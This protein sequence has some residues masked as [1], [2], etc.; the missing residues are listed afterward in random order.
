MDPFNGIAE[1][2][3]ADCIKRLKLLEEVQYI[4]ENSETTN[5]ALRLLFKHSNFYTEDI[6]EINSIPVNIERLK[7]C[8]DGTE[9]GESYLFMVLGVSKLS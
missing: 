8:I 4:F 3:K 5:L 2:F 7:N 6:A 1:V 9:V